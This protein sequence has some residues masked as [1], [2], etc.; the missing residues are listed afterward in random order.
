MLTIQAGNR[1]VALTA[2]VSVASVFFHALSL[3][4]ES[5]IVNVDP[6]FR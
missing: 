5:G 6:T 1:G 4:L 2:Y 3:W